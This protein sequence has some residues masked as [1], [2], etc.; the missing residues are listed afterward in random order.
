MNRPSHYVRTLAIL[1]GLLIPLMATAAPANSEPKAPQ[2]IAQDTVQTLL[3]AMQ[4]RRDELRANPQQLY[5]LVNR[6]LVPLVDL[7]YMSQLVLGRY[8]RIATPQQRE[9]FKQA[10]KAMLVRTY[11]SALLGFD[12]ETVKYLPVRASE[13]ADNITFRAIVITES[14]DQVPV[15]LDMHLVDGQWKV[16]DGRVGSLSLVTNYRSQF[17]NYIQNKGLESLI[18]KMEQRYGI[19]G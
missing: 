4:G 8:W 17:S 12:D 1:L 7:D 14:G 3:Q 11:A 10:F 9:R 15:A 6:I 13:N 18:K 19:S 16:Y 5:A 2:Q